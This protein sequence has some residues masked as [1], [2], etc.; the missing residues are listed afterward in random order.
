MKRRFGLLLVFA[1]LSAA[2]TFFPDDPL[3]KEPPPVGIKEIKT[4]KL[5]DYYDFILNTFARPDRGVKPAPPGAVNTFG[6][7][8]D[9]AWY[10]RRHYYGRMSLEQLKLGPGG[11]TPPSMKSPWT[12]IR[13]KGEG[14]TPGF[15]IIDAEKR[16]YFLKFD[17]WSNP[18]MSTAA[19]AISARLFH[20]LGY[21]VPDNYVVYFDE[22][23]LEL[24]KGVQLLDHLGRRQEMTRRHLLEILLKAY[25]D[26]SGR[27]R[28]IASK[29]VAGRPLGPFRYHGQRT[30]DPNDIVPHQDRLDLRGLRVF[31]A[32]LN[33]EDSRAVNTLDTLVEEAGVSYVR[34][35]L[36]DFGSTL[37]S[38]STKANPPRSGHEQL[39]DWRMA[40]FHMFTLGLAVPDWARVHY[41]DLPSIGRFEAATFHPDKWVP[42]YPNPAFENCGPV[43]AFWAAKQVMSFT[44]DEIAAVVSA[45]YL[46]NAEAQRHLARVLRERRDKVGRAYLERVLPLD[47]FE[48]RDGRVAFEDLGLKHGLVSERVLTA[49][50]FHFDNAKNTRTPISGA[51]TF[52]IPPAAQSPGYYGIQIR[53]KGETRRGVTAYVRNESGRMRIVGIE[54]SW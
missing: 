29:A 16:M 53:Q 24:G 20:A 14:I 45:G 30:D 11:R 49:E 17:P 42:E 35:F 33:H 13:A 28:A 5:S 32:W 25:K 54:R 22:N 9:G 38:A 7:P 41:P 26:E 10:T 19:D 6:E 40:A 4:R 3:E 37:G 2:Q 43:E 12:V 31:C 48:V 52:Q 15:T 18:E 23:Q 50:W 44:D 1:G 47:R 34:H 36:I 8:M 51:Q 27:Y 21:H 46:T 39:F